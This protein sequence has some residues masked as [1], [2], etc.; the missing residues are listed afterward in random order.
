MSGNVCTCGVKFTGGICSSWC[1]LQRPGVY[2][3]DKGLYIR[4]ELGNKQYVKFTD[5]FDLD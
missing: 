5:L 3:D 1:D 2:V 4:D